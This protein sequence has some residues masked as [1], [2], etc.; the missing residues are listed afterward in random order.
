MYPMPL[1]R[2]ELLEMANQ[3]QDMAGK[4]KQER[5]AV[6]SHT[7]A[8]VS[9]ALM[10]V[11]ATAH[12]ICE[13]LPGQS[14]GSGVATNVLES[15]PSPACGGP[16]PPRGYKP[17]QLRGLSAESNST[18][19][20]EGNGPAIARAPA[21]PGARRRPASRRTGLRIPGTWTILM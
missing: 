9:M 18:V 10:G 15:C 6:A 21:G 3:S 2:P 11:T 20:L 8:M 4:A 1:R 17:S 19:M 12:L 13:T 16:H 14:A 5:M 7:V